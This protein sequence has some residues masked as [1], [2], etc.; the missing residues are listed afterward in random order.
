MTDI[1][2]DVLKVGDIL[3]A[4]AGMWQVMQSFEA[5]CGKRRKCPSESP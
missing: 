2:D 5:V 3:A 4:L 1:G